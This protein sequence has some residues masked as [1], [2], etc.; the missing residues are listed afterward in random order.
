MQ[1]VGL[2]YELV[3]TGGSAK[4]IE[5]AGF[6]VTTVEE[7]TGFPEML[8][9]KQWICLIFAVGNK[10]HMLRYALVA[11]SSDISLVC[12]TRSSAVIVETL[13]RIPNWSI[14]LTS[15]AECKIQSNQSNIVVDAYSQGLANRVPIWCA[16]C[17]LI[18]ECQ[19]GHFTYRA[20]Q[21]HAS[22]SFW[23]HRR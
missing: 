20:F 15:I 13:F 11:I 3:S 14:L 9:G 2:G 5:T 1:P 8:D 18:G 22:D 6:P 10:G 4:A 12:R 17:K 23:K 16:G 21:I 19:V 7:L